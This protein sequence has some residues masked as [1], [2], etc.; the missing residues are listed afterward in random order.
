MKKIYVWVIVGILIAAVAL[1]MFY[2]VG[3]GENEVQWAKEEITGKWRTELT[4]VFT[5]GTEIPA[6]D[7]YNNN[8]L[9]YRYYD[10]EGS[11]EIQS[12][13][14]EIFATATTDPGGPSIVYFDWSDFVLNANIMKYGTSEEIYNQD[15][16]CDG[17]G[18]SS[19]P[20]FNFYVPFEDNIPVDG[21][22]HYIFGVAWDLKNNVDL[23]AIIDANPH[24]YDSDTIM[25]Y[26]FGFRN[27]GS[28]KYRS[29]PLDDWESILQ[30][31]QATIPIDVV[32]NLAYVSL[33]GYITPIY[34]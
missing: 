20:H 30:P 31:A 6:E 25:T 29:D 2:P 15:V 27:A 3:A 14:Y 11:V 19:V 10:F 17:T 23:E 8:V 12:L 9:S 26:S 34:V 28:I 24:Y 1:Y 32:E 21:E 5:D 16:T 33:S 18:G 7:L 4:V 13:K 22:E